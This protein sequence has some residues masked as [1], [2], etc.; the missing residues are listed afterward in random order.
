MKICSLTLKAIILQHYIP[1]SIDFT[2]FSIHLLHTPKNSFQLTQKTML[3]KNLCHCSVSLSTIFDSSVNVLGPAN[4]DIWKRGQAAGICSS[5]DPN[6]KLKHRYLGTLLIVSRR[7]NDSRTSP[8]M[9]Y[10]RSTTTPS[11]AI[12]LLSTKSW[13]HFR[14]SN[15]ISMLL[16]LY[17]IFSSKI[18]LSMYFFVCPLFLHI[19]HA[20]FSFRLFMIM[21]TLHNLSGVF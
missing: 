7:Q 1:R 6:R 17:Q 19:L 20:T 4:L 9:L 21:S 15:L 14:N 8:V 13:N 3:K 10:I 5:K 12:Y 2:N 18:C 11:W 16:H